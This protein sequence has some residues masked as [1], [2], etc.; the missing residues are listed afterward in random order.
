MSLAQLGLAIGIVFASALGIVLGIELTLDWS[1]V[2]E[3][4]PRTEH[5]NLF[6]DMALAGIVT[7]GFAVFYNASKMD[8]RVC[9]LQSGITDRALPG[10]G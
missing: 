9:I 8:T 5:L 10:P 1:V 3:P 7:C 6:S 4:G 2:S